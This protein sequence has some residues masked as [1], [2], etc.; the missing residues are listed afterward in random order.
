MNQLLTDSRMLKPLFFGNYSGYEST[1]VHNGVLTYFM[2]EEGMIE[3]QSDGRGV[4][5]TDGDVTV[6]EAFAY[7]DNRIPLF[8]PTKTQ[9]STTNYRACLVCNKEE[10]ESFY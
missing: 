6:E 1:Y 10:G 9:T 7:A 8:S 2:V 3:G 4:G 5:A